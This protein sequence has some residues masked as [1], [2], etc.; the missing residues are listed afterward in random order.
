[1]T[2]AMLRK[3]KGL[4]GKDVAEK[5]GI[6][7]GYYNHLENGRRSFN[8]ELIE[9]LSEVLG[10]PV[11]IISEKVS[12]IDDESILTRN[13]VMNIK[14]HGQNVL[15]AFEYELII[16]PTGDLEK[17]LK[18][19]FAD[20]IRNNIAQSVLTE[21]DHDSELLDMLIKKYRPLETKKS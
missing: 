16:N 7:P 20:F 5:M 17:N 15:K 14:I 3:S 12:Q 9:K 2:L 10:E 19:R 18:F 8:R 11:E 4:S 13:W 21:L 1:M 6:T